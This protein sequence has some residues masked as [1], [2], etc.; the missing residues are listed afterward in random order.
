MGNHYSEQELRTVLQATGGSCPIHAGPLEI[1]R[2]P[3]GYPEFLCRHGHTFSPEYYSARV[4]GAHLK[5]AVVGLQD[6]LNRPDLQV[7]YEDFRYFPMQRPPVDLRDFH[8][9]HGGYWETRGITRNTLEAYRAGYLKSDPAI[10]FYDSHGV[11]VGFFTRNSQVPPDTPYQK[12]NT[13]CA[14]HPVESTHWES[15]RLHFPPE[16]FPASQGFMV[17]VEGILDAMRCR[18]AGFYACS[19]NGARVGSSQLAEV[20]PITDNILIFTDDDPAGRGELGHPT[21]SPA[22][23][24]FFNVQKLMPQGAKDPGG[25]G[26]ETLRELLASVV[27]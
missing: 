11:I 19:I 12:H 15:Y 25:M 23:L 17:L 10:P 2:G 24:P 9:D 3:Y 18:D 21:V 7:H 16:R 20:L 4:R 1:Q 8:Q 5:T 6:L 27:F 26:I 22:L 14:H 13:K